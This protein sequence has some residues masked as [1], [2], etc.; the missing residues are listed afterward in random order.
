MVI[1]T[2]HPDMDIGEE[3]LNEA[4]FI[5]LISAQVSVAAMMMGPDFAFAAL[6]VVLDA[7]PSLER[8]IAAMKRHIGGGG[9]C[10][11]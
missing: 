9:E 10:P 4:A 7:R 8:H 11:G 6:K 1:P 5:Q 2:E 3:R